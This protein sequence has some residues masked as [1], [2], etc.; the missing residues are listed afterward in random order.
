[1]SSVVNLKNGMF[2]ARCERSDCGAARLLLNVTVMCKGAGCQKPHRIVELHLLVGFPRS[3]LELRWSSSSD[4]LGDL[5]RPGILER[6]D[7]LL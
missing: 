4:I 5:T 3:L 2:S 6:R 1:M 7:E